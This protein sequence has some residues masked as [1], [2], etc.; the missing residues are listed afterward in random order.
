MSFRA[1]ALQSEESCISWIAEVEP[2]VIQS[3]V[4]GFNE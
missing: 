3:G 2:N 1:L 4:E